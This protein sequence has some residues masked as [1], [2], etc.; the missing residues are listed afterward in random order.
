M[1]LRQS[2]VVFTATHRQLNEINAINLMVMDEAREKKTL[3]VS[4]SFQTNQNCKCDI[5]LF[6]RFATFFHI[7]R[8]KDVT[9]MKKCE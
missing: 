7:F 3:I 9:N 6:F 4:F 8:I 2:G 1:S 5:L